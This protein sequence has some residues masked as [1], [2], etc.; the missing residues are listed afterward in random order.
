MI[1]NLTLAMCKTMAGLV[2]RMSRCRCPLSSQRLQLDSLAWFP[3][4][5]LARAVDLPAGA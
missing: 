5:L 1:S 2:C 3:A 4:T